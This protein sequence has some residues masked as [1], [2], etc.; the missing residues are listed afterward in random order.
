MH[1]F[2]QTMLAIGTA[3]CSMAVPQTGL[4]QAVP[5]DTS[6]TV[7]LKEAFRY[8]MGTTVSSPSYLTDWCGEP[9]L[10]VVTFATGSPRRALT[11]RTLPQLDTHSLSGWIGTT[12]HF[13]IVPLD[14]DGVPPSEYITGR[15]AVLSVVPSTDAEKQFRPIDTIGCVGSERTL[16]DVDGDG[17]LDVVT[18]TVSATTWYTVVLSGPDRGKGCARTISFPA[19]PYMNSPLRM[20]RCADGK[21]R[22]VGTGKS[23]NYTG[24]Y[25]LDVGVVR[26]GETYDIS[27]S[28]ADSLTAHNFPSDQAW[29]AIPLVAVDD[30]RAGKQYAAFYWEAGY[31]KAVKAAA[32][33]DISAGVLTEQQYNTDSVMQVGPQSFDNTF[34]DGPAV[35]AYFAKGK[36]YFARITDLFRPFASIVAELGIGPKLFIDDQTGDGRRDLL[37]TSGQ[38][39]PGR[40]TVFDFDYTRTDVHEPMRAEAPWAQLDGRVLRL[41]LD[42]P[43]PVSIDAVDMKGSS[44]T[45]LSSQTDATGPMTYDLTSVLS[46]LPAGPYLLQIKAGSRTTTIKYIR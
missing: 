13:S 26:S 17:R 4:A 40:V 32:V 22:I 42:H 7:E 45:I 5:F 23:G 43:A 28:V 15:G 10:N 20:L 8:E 16:V 41:M 24:V 46:P 36:H 1:S 39:D 38:L 29:V 12:G 14:Y 37:V 35:V 3:L 11:W 19:G 25:L 9:G 6:R 33:Y 30:Q 31:F 21:L 2:A 18:K 34:D 44:R 27:Y